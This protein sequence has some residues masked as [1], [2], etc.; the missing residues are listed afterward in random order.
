MEASFLPI[1]PCE[2]SIGNTAFFAILNVRV[3]VCMHLYVRQ[4]FFFCPF[5]KTY[6][7]FRKA[8]TATNERVCTHA[9]THV[10]TNVCT[11]A[12]TVSTGSARA[13][14]RW[15]FEGRPE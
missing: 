2:M 6:K 11:H 8:I 13:R 1:C 14:Q 7:K 5:F 4:S 9:H 12:I 15:Q 3:Y 10:R